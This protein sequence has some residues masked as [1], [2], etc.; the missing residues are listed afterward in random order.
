[1][2][3]YWYIDNEEAIANA[4]GSDLEISKELIRKRNKV[5]EEDKS[6]CKNK[7]Y[8]CKQKFEAYFSMTKKCAEC[9]ITGRANA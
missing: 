8:V 2:T 4:F 6:K 9:E 7:C 5:I 1:M 3:N